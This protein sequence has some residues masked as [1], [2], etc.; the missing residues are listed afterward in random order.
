MA[1]AGR[2]VLALSGLSLTFLMLSHA[3]LGYVVQVAGWNQMSGD[4]AGL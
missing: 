4:W 1:A 2:L 3:I